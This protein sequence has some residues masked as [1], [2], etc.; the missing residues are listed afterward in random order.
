MLQDA[1]L[2]KS[3]VLM[4]MATQTTLSFESRAVVDF[5]VLVPRSP[6]DTTPPSRTSPPTPL[7]SRSPVEPPLFETPSRRTARGASSLATM[8]PIT[9][10]FGVDSGG[11]GGSPY[12]Q[13]LSPIKSEAATS[14]RDDAGDA[15]G[16]AAAAADASKSPWGESTLH[17]MSPLQPAT[18]GDWRAELFRETDWGAVPRPRPQAPWHFFEHDVGFASPARPAGVRPPPHPAG[19]DDYATTEFAS[20]WQPMPVSPTLTNLTGLYR[21]RVQQ[22]TL[23]SAFRSS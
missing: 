8:S 18:R 7:R 5:N 2:Q 13:P 3:A 14:P 17:T 22:R 4:D 16:A 1:G 11:R 23:L 9:P 15:G 10:A 12:G 19:W 6:A 20:S 21:K